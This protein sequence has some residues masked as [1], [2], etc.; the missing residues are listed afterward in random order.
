MNSLKNGPNLLLIKNILVLPTCGHSF[1]FSFHQTVH[2]VILCAYKS[3]LQNGFIFCPVHFAKITASQQL[4]AFKII[5]LF[6]I[7]LL[8]WRLDITK[9]RIAN[10]LSAWNL[11][12]DHSIELW[13]KSTLIIYSCMYNCTWSW[14]VF[15]IFE[16]R[17]KK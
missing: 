7:L 14:S 8:I 10:L 6:R 1:T 13:R 17:W 11:P 5:T 12:F 15:I 4:L 16:C 2:P 3:F 9:I